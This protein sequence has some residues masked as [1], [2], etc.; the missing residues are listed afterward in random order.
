M[1]FKNQGISRGQG[2]WEE[3]E[4]TWYTF[5]VRCPWDIPAGGGVPSGQVERKNHGCGWNPMVRQSKIENYK[6]RKATEGD[7]GV[8]RDMME[9]KREE[10]CNVKKK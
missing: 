7:L 6:E 9:I 1:S 2:G 5:N 3:D 4:C 10:C 8:L